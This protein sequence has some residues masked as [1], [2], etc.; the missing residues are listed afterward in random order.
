MKFTKTQLRVMIVLGTRWRFE[1]GGS[2]WSN[3]GELSK[4]IRRSIVATKRAVRGLARAGVVDLTWLSDDE[5]FV[6]GRGYLLTAAWD[7]FL[8]SRRQEQFRA[9]AEFDKQR[10][11]KQRPKRQY[12]QTE[13]MM[14]D[15][16]DDWNN[17]R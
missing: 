5:G 16:I 11:K 9:V 13:A 12:D 10:A 6:R 1:E 8:E 4:E 15:R 7:N 14:N 3:F 2:S 17:A